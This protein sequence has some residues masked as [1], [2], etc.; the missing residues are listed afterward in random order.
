[1][2]SADGRGELQAV[3]EQLVHYVGVVV[4]HSREQRQVEGGAGAVPLQE[5]R[6]LKPL[7]PAHPGTAQSSAGE[8]ECHQAAALCAPI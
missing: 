5:G 8:A 1:M 3:I 7:P 6:Q 4:H 2:F